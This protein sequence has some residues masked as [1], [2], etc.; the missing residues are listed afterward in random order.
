VS[1]DAIED[2]ECRTNDRK[3]ADQVKEASRRQQ[4][5]PLGW[6]IIEREPD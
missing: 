4:K 5:K 1:P 6:L 2:R 3:K